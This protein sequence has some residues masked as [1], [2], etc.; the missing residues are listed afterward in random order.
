MAIIYRAQIRP[1]K[2]EL[3]GSWLPPQPWFGSRRVDRLASLGAYRFDDPSGGVGIETLLVGVAGVVVQVPMTYRGAPLAGAEA[4]LMG[5][6]EHSVLGTRW[7]YDACADP[8]YANELAT[9]ILTGGTQ[10][11]EF[12]EGDAGPT[13]RASTASVKGSGAPDAEVMRVANVDDLSVSTTGTASTITAPTWELTV[14]RVVES[15][16]SFPR[17]EAELIG[18]WAAQP[19]PVRLASGRHR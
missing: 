10:V 8:V 2:L 11:D 9:A 14:A 16:G 6:M 3:I 4:A 13:L 18:T 15:G 1:T 5:T 7:V 12:V 19:Q 17:V